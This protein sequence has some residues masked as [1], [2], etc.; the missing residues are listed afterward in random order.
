MDRKIT[1][2]IFVGCGWI[3]LWAFVIGATAL[4]IKFAMW[5]VSLL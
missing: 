3:A 5:A 4:A 2:A 1:T